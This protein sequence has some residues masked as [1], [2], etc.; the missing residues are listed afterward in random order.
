MLQLVTDPYRGWIFVGAV[1]LLAT[2]LRYWKTRPAF[3]VVCLDVAIP[4][5]LFAECAAL[6]EAVDENLVG[7]SLWRAAMVTLIAGGVIAASRFLRIRFLTVVAVSAWVVATLAL[8][9]LGL[10]MPDS[11]FMDRETLYFLTTA[12]FALGAAFTA[13]KLVKTAPPEREGHE[14][15]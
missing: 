12:F 11:L 2:V 1:L 8:V 13:T 3:A 6:I 4:V 9:Q 14:P 7:S 10:F 5:G 15:T